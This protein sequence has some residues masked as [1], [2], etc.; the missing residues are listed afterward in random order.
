MRPRLLTGLLVAAALATRA[1]SQQA[2]NVVVQVRVVDSA[3]APIA[4]A[5]VSILRGLQQVLANGATDDRGR[6]TLVM[7]REDGDYQISARRIGYTRTD[8]FFAAPKTD[9]VAF[10]LELR[11]TPQ[12]LAPVAIS[13]RESLR[14]RSY[15]IDADEIA[16]SSRPIFNALDVLQKLKPDMLLG[17]SGL[18][19]LSHVWVNGKRIIDFTPNPMAEARRPMA[20]PPA[21][22][23]PGYRAPNL[24]SRL[25]AVAVSPWNI[26]STIKPEHISEITYA[27]CDD[28]TVVAVGAQAAA[29]VVLKPG[30]RFEAGIGSMPDERATETAATSL[31]DVSTAR[32]IPDSMSYRARVL[33]IFDSA[34]GQPVVDVEVIDLA[35]GTKAKTT[36]T[37]TVSL[38]YLAEGPGK[39]RL[40]KAGYADQ[41]LD[42]EITPGKTLPITAILI[43]K[44]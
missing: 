9:T 32:A 12:S 42:V 28:T 13:E 3:G 6:R 24:G 14:R 43:P 16:A 35:T 15:H 22:V 27:D 1:E 36:S 31:P 18:C 8:R 19:A 38:Q 39:V 25:S 26:L 10:E 11:R 7:P 21:S 17:R 40:Q 5:D 44:A 29:F 4:G 30:V 41:E 2:K 34:T 37:G 20:P 23:P 33:G